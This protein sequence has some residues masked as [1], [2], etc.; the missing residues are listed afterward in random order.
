MAYRFSKRSK[1]R[2]EGINPL[3]INILLDGIKD[4]PYDFGIPRDGGFRTLQRQQELY[5]KGRTT[6]KLR[7]KGIEDI[8]GRPNASKI[9][10]TLNS[11]HR[12]GN[13]FDIYAYVDGKASWSMKYLEPIARH[14][15]KIALEEFDTELE[16]GYDL[17][18]KDGAHF[19]I[20]E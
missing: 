17:W 7:S 15:Q 1:E 16:W 18:K 14:L 2:I 6:E 10:W 12:T 8:E 3:L 13:A 20:K 5:A 4:S 9:T 19:Q 11:Y